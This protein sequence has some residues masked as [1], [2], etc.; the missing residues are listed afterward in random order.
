MA[1]KPLHVVCDSCHHRYVEVPTRSFLG[2]QRTDC[3]ACGV[4]VV[5]PL[6]TGYRVA[7]ALLGLMFALSTLQAFSSSDHGLE[8]GLGAAVWLIPFVVA[9]MT[10]MSIAS[11]VERVTMAAAKPVEK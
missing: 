8:R 2:F 4:Q 1:L 3:P 6:T 10:D 5:Y 7:Y 11:R 9:I